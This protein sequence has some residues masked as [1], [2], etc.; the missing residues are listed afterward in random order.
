MVPVHFYGPEE[1]F[2][3]VPQRNVEVMSAASL[4]DFVHDA[5]DDEGFCQALEQAVA[6]H[7]FHC[8]HCPDAA[9][10]DAVSMRSHVD[11]IHP[12]AVL[13]KALCQARF[14][15]YRSECLQLLAE[16][17]PQ[18]MAAADISL[19]VALLAR[20][21][22]H[23]KLLALTDDLHRAPV[24]RCTTSG[25]PGA[26]KPSVQGRGGQPTCQVCGK[27]FAGK[28]ALYGH[29]RIHRTSTVSPAPDLA[30]QR[31]ATATP[32]QRTA[33]G[34]PDTPVT[35][36]TFPNA[37]QLLPTAE[38]LRAK[39][40][41][42]G[43]VN[44]GLTQG[45]RL[46]G[47][48]GP[49]NFLQRLTAAAD[50]AIATGGHNLFSPRDSLFLSPPTEAEDALSQRHLLPLHF[51]VSPPPLLC[52]PV[53]SERDRMPQINV[54]PFYQAYVPAITGNN[55][56][57]GLAEPD[58]QRSELVWHPDVAINHQ[59]SFHHFLDF[60]TTSALFDGVSH[61]QRLELAHEALHTGF[62][63]PE[64]PGIPLM[65]AT[66]LKL[67][68]ARSPLMVRPSHATHWTSEE[69]TTFWEGLIRHGKQFKLIQRMLG[70]KPLAAII[71]FYY[72]E[73]HKADN[74]VHM[75]AYCQRR[76]EDRA[77]CEAEGV[78]VGLSERPGSSFSELVACFCL[79]S[80]WCVYIFSLNG[81][82]CLLLFM[83][84]VVGV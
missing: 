67:T 69:K 14:D 74:R 52:A 1:E 10:H 46:P 76:A 49:S 68:G 58:Q 80:S 32:T 37:F 20:P 53:A 59:P 2:A 35:P 22:P 72:L 44:A 83:C 17:D 26:S 50:V 71:Q 55:G 75:E 73:K 7:T 40:H 19:L 81:F 54:G 43:A 47:H 25:L 79:G 31:P 60:V 9:F 65:T 51:T 11:L 34:L 48:T 77:R 82:Y 16:V 23:N 13:S 63:G 18:R 29:M 64:H 84:S 5:E 24:A 41:T 66:L 38:L 70:T 15:V 28:P 36:T 27:V 57:W 4:L 56:G 42:A 30:L 39:P 8:P 3:W 6:L 33:A 45:Q 78:V 61:D 21:S 62:T 12:G